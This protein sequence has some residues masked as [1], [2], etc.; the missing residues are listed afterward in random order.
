MLSGRDIVK[1][2]HEHLANPTNTYE[3]IL[4]EY[5]DKKDYVSA[6]SIGKCPRAFAMRK[7]EIAPKLPELETDND[8]VALMRMQGG[9]EAGITFARAMAE[10]YGKSHGV[11]AEQYLCDEE[12]K[13]HGFADVVIDEGDVKTVIEVKKRAGFFNSPA[14]AML[15]DC[16]QLLSYGL[17]L[18]RQQKQF[19][20][21]LVILDGS[22][23]EPI[24]VYEL[25]RSA[26]GFE[27]RDILNA[28]FDTETGEVFLP[29]RL[30]EHPLNSPQFLNFN[31]MLEKIETVR[32]WLERENYDES[33]IPDPV[34]SKMGY[35]CI[36]WEGKK[37]T[38]LVTKSTFGVITPRCPYSCHFNNSYEK[39]EVEVHPNG[40]YEVLNN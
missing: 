15:T 12:L 23:K 11:K 37:P 9:K 34:N 31:A 28:T 26:S 36:M 30:W 7:K 32:S 29:Y 25:A 20:L 21:L 39:K 22:Q 14:S 35:Q 19:R 16:Y 2:Y 40:F 24:H 18:S 17:I 8:L 1:A 5:V 10:K 3:L 33:P 4:D 13:F 27:L 6:S 38:P